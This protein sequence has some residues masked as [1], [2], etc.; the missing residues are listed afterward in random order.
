[1]SSRTFSTAPSVAAA[2]ARLRELDLVKPPGVAEAIDWAAALG[3]LGTDTLTE[4]LAAATL[5]AVLKVR[6]DIDRVLALGTL[7]DG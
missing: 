2:M 7:D 4:E 6:E 3:T 5:G 1:M